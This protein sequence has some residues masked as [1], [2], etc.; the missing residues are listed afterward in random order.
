MEDTF[1][2]IYFAIRVLSY[3]DIF[4]SHCLEIAANSA[5]IQMILEAVVIIEERLIVMHMVCIT[6]V[7]DLHA[8]YPFHATVDCNF[9][10]NHETT[11]ISIVSSGIGRAVRINMSE[12]G[13]L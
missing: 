4:N 1:K 9:I 2:D 7:L 11:E 10:T 5:N 8:I 6:I 3:F 12:V 13:Y